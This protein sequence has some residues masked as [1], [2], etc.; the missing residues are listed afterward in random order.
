MGIL[1]SVND[2]LQ[3]GGLE[4]IARRGANAAFGAGADRLDS[5]LG[6]GIG[7]SPVNQNLEDIYGYF[8]GTLLQSANSLPLTP[9]WLCFLDNIPNTASRAENYDQNGVGRHG[10]SFYQQAATSNIDFRGAKGALLA[11]QI[12]LPFEQYSTQ[13]GSQGSVGGFLQ[14]GLGSARA[15]SGS[16]SISYLET[17]YS[18]T[19]F[20]LRPWTIVAEYESLKI[21]PRTN[22]TMINFAKAGSKSQFVPRKIVTLHNC[23]PIS[24]DS[25]SYNYKGG[26]DVMIRSVNW[27]YDSYTIKSGQLIQERDLLNSLDRVLNINFQTA[28]DLLNPESRGGA[29]NTLARSGVQA[30]AG[31]LNNLVT[32]IA[33]DLGE[34]FQDNVDRLVGRESQPN[35]RVG[36]GG[37]I[38]GDTANDNIQGIVQQT[39]QNINSNDTVIS[40]QLNTI[41]R[42]IPNEDT[43]ESRILNNDVL[44]DPNDTP[45]NNPAEQLPTEVTPT[46]NDVVTRQIAAAKRGSGG[47][48][49]VD[50]NQDTPTNINLQTDDVQIPQIDTPEGLRLQTT[51]ELRV[52]ENDTYKSIPPSNISLQSQEILPDNDT[53]NVNTPKI[54]DDVMI[55]NDNRNVNT[56]RIEDDVIITNDVRSNNRGTVKDDVAINP[57][58]R[59]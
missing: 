4:S 7:S 51:P 58:D 41:S 10:M 21:A 49:Q 29:I 18:F 3:P 19:D 30:G 42:A 59:I 55:A 37:Q 26:E 12:N 11:Q 47:E 6:T 24:I 8:L 13:V 57:E 56:S 5:F 52:N 43:P 32:N 33:G 34:R 16:A 50:P 14:G 25:E 39:N 36:V 35:S 40:S 45:I 17:N 22:I 54:V 2:I 38:L 1:D 53:R 23:L 44:I 46:L 20:G 9:L 48:E 15:Q 27:W 31:F 28:S